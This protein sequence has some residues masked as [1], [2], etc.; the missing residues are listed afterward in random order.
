MIT[1]AIS[2]SAAISASSF[3]KA[4]Y[5]RSKLCGEWEKALALLR[6]M[7]EAGMTTNVIGFSAAISACEKDGQRVL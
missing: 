7:R 4:Q 1:N 6:K 5:T 3:G 2:F